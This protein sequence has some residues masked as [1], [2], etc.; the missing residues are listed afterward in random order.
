MD[1]KFQLDDLRVFAL[2]ARKASFAATAMELGTSAAYVSKRIAMLEKA[3]GVTLFHRAARRVTVTD[4]GERVYQSAQAIFEGVERMGE[5]VAGGRLDPRGALRVTTSFR[6]GRKHIAPALSELARRHPALRITLDVVDRR[7][8]LIAEN[9]DLDVRVAEVDEPHLV[10]HRIAGS[11]KVLSAAPH[12]LQ[13]RGVPEGIAA[14]ARHDCLVLRDRHQAFGVWRLCGPDGFEKVK[15]TGRLSSNN[16]EIVRAWAADG[17]GILL[18]AHWDVA[19]DLNHGRLVHLLP[20]YS[21]P[22][23]IWAASTVRLSHSAKVR[24]CVAF[25]QEQLTS[26]PFALERVGG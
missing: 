9:I 14:L 15:V 2:A 1:L 20:A 11:K 26:G 19:A 5:T 17:Q 3:L 21:E 12:Y 8:D 10:A 6:L 7:V 16:S 24:V 23:D 4:D 22:A 13:R 18:S 25:L